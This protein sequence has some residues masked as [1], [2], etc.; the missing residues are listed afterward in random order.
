MNVKQISV[1]L[2]NKAGKLSALTRLLADNHV[3]LR[4]LSIA[5]TQDFG[6][7]RLIAEKP[8][9][10][11]MILSSAGYVCNVT[12]VLA[13]SVDDAPGAVAKVLTVLSDADVDVEYAY[14]FVSS[15]RAGCA[16]MVLRVSS[17][18]AAAAALAAASVTVL[19]QEELA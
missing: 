13:V 6:I 3:N 19:S 7:L 5:D 8:S 15:R 11:A 10:V 9:E 16:N 4:A 12:D 18:D 1:F 2:E 14:A 17:T